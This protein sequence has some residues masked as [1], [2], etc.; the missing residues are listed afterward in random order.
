MNNKT[1]EPEKILKNINLEVKHNEHIVII[2]PSGSGKS[3]FLRCLNL[4][5]I[6][7]SGDIIFNNQ[8]I[9]NN[10]NNNKI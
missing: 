6:P 5:E 7:S 2:G 9:N 10:K 1:H 3:T 4:L 8:N